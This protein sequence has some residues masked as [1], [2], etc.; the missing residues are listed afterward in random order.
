V[1]LDAKSIAALKL[2]KTDAIYFDDAMAGFGYRLR[3]GAGGK[4]LRSWVVQ[5]KRAGA[6]RRITLG[7]A[8][9]LAAEAART[10][11]RKLLAKVALG[12][13]P[14]AARVDRRGKD[15]LTMRS[16]AVEYLAAK[17]HE[18]AK[19][20]LIEMRRYL[21][22]AR[23]F[24]PLHKLA[25]DTITRRD[26]AARV[27]VIMR[28]CG[29]PTAARARG[30]FSSFFTWAMRMG[31]CE[32]NPTI[33][34][35]APAEDGGRDR[36]LSDTELAAIWRACHDDDFGRIIR[37]L[38]LGAWRR[39][40][41]GDMC[42]SE[43]D[44][45]ERPTTFTVPAARSKNGR[46]HTLPLTPT[47]VR[48]IAGVPRMA[49]RDQLFGQRSHGFTRWHESKAELDARSGA[50]GWTIH[51]LRRSV[52]TRMADLGVQPH[53]I[54]AV[55]NHQ[56][57]HK[58]GPAGVYNRSVYANEVRTALLMWDDHI[59][60]LIDGGERKVIPYAPATAS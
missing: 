49:S 20:T 46:A 25:I 41:I 60:A 9:V 42:W 58:R 33:G 34:S 59:R 45:P 37:L 11:A 35:V 12:E 52:A 22:D 21:T 44:D 31:L 23:Y 51:D 18:L 54:E 38:A 50:V 7:A 53:I 13:D 27:V 56:S 57:G 3:R 36:V 39:A 48:I 6:T 55:L 4:V 8:E 17:E 5:Y 2:D 15:L 10:A 24:G 30:A 16:Q 19:R 47:M 43:L 29:N 40:E 32:S 1:K 14:Q 26:V 28:E